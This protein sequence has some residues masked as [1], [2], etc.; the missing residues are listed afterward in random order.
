MHESETRMSS[1]TKTDEGPLFGATAALSLYGLVV[2]IA[3]L[4]H[5]ELIPEEGWMLGVLMVA[6]LVVGAI[7]GTL[8][9][10]VAHRR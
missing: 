4:F 7:A 2:I 8:A 3:S 9:D 10:S 5:V 1:R 6:V